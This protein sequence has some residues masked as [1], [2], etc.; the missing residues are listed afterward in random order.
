M[1]WRSGTTEKSS[2]TKYDIPIENELTADDIHAKPP[3]EISS[4]VK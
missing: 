3:V 4:Q 1:M 2:T